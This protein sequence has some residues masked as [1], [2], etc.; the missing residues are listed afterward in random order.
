MTRL[1][2][3]FR[4]GLLFL[5]LLSCVFAF[6]CGRYGADADFGNGATL[7]IED[8]VHSPLRPE[9][10]LHP[11][12]HPDRELTALMF[13][14]RFQQNI[15]NPLHYGREIGRI[16]WQ[17]WLKEKVFPVFEYQQKRA[18]P[19][20]EAA[21]AQARAKG[22]DLA[23]GGDITLFMAGG[24][25]GDSRLAL[26]LEIYDAYSGALIW[27]MAHMGELKSE[28]LSDYLLFKKKVTMP[29]DPIYAIVVKLAED[30]SRPISSWMQPVRMQGNKESEL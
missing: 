1:P 8:K 5:A 20:G 21:V 18:W 6:G 11:K 28:V 24:D 4:A 2:T 9:I 29:S 16:F 17:V 10:Y 12:D 13:P 19:G 15:E 22:A 7:Y 27:S 14:F 3:T 23:I 26:R 25:Y 30:M